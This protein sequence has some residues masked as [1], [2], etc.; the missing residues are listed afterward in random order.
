MIRVIEFMGEFD[1]ITH[2]FMYFAFTKLVPIYRNIIK[3]RAKKRKKE[4]SD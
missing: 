2:K 3:N 1:L 4:N